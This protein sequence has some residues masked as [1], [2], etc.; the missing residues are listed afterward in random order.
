[1]PREERNTIDLARGLFPR[2]AGGALFALPL[3]KVEL[4]LYRVHTGRA[5]PTYENPQCDY[6]GLICR[7]SAMFRPRI[8]S[9]S[10]E[11]RNVQW[12]LT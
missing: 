4:A 7:S 6:Y 5:N 10:P 2:V 1:M 12:R 9:F 11:L 8:W 3:D